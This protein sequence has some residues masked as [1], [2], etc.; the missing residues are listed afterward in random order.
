MGG[1]R[2]EILLLSLSSNHSPTIVAPSLL[3][4]Y[5]VLYPRGKITIHKMYSDLDQPQENDALRTGRS[6]DAPSYGRGNNNNNDMMNA[7][8]PTNRLFFGMKKTAILKYVWTWNTGMIL[9]FFI[10]GCATA[11]GEF[12]GGVVFSFIFV[13]F[14]AIAVSLLG[15]QIMLRPET[16]SEEK[17][18]MLVAS[19]FFMAMFSFNAS[20]DAGSFNRTFYESLGVNIPAVRST[21]AFGVFLL[22]GYSTALYMLIY[23]KHELKWNMPLEVYERRTESNLTDLGR[24][25][26]SI[27]IDDDNTSVPTNVT[28]N[29][30]NHGTNGVANAEYLETDL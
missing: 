3:N 4:K 29:N 6:P 13:T 5:N 9:P 24:S 8:F 25:F 12:P 16:R 28:N 26:D 17:Y 19:A 23:W 1:W 7:D 21:I 20:V 10:S 2:N 14:I 11:G 15:Y 30:N 22:L 27:H 18:G